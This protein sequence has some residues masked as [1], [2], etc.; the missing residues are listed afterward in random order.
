[1]SDNEL[2]ERA[3]A[4]RRGVTRLSRRLRLE[5]PEQGEPPL[6]LSALALLYAHGPMTP[7]DLAAAE[8]VQP[9]S[10]TR[11][12][13]AVEAAG[14]VIRQP[15]PDD[16]RSVLLTITDA[17]RRAISRD[18]RQRD[19]WLAL[20][21]ASQLTPTE[22]ELLRLAGELMERLAE[23]EVST[24]PTAPPPPTGHDGLSPDPAGA[25]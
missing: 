11:T 25:G 9:Q 19:S 15:A 8:R 10:L 7:G 1:M 5:R 23:A 21:F 17:G 20:A 4:L 12:L 14:L 3:T 6:Q 2:L 16:G 18:V 24:L 13:A 22:Q